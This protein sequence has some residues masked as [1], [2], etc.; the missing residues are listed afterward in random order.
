MKNLR[1]LSKFFFLAAIA[2]TF[3]FTGCVTE[4]PALLPVLTT[5]EVTG[6]SYNSAVSGGVIS[7]DGGSIVTERGVCWST[8]GTPKVSDNKTTDGGGVGTFTSTIT[9]L[10][11]AIIYYVRAYAKTKEGIGYG[12]AYQFKT[13]SFPET[14]L[15]PAGTF[16]MGSPT[17]EVSRYNDETQHEVTLSAFRMS[18]YEITTA[19][20][21]GFLNAKGIGSDGKYASGAYPTQELFYSEVDGLQSGLIYTN[22]QWIPASGYENNPIVFVTWYGATEYATYIG[23]SLPTE[24]QWEYVCRAG[25]TTPFNTGSCLTNLQAN[26]DWGYPYSTCTNSNTTEPGKTQP[27][28]TYAPNGYGLYDMHGNVWEWCADWYG[29]YPTAAQTNPTGPS[30]GSYRVIRGGSWSFNAPRCRSANRD[31]SYPDGDYGGIGF[32]VV[33]VP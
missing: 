11:P 7:S 15:I 14:V 17:S 22:N 2:V 23:G 5:T 20:F 9:G 25:T 30:T 13:I 19:Q 31:R 24:A 16:T 12:S 27:V 33:F 3:L 1:N 21:A 4:N 10:E 28:G 8:T 29:T 32:R 6:I 18:K 26:Y